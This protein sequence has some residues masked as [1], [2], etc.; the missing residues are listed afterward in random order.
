[1]P[2]PFE[3]FQQLS[4]QAA[5]I[6]GL[7]A[8][9]DWDQET[10]MPNDGLETRARQRS[11]LAQAHHRLSTGPQLAKA[12]GSCIDLTTG[13]LLVE[14]PDR[15]LR[16]LAIA[17]EDYLKQKKVPASWVKQLSAITPF[18][19]DAWARARK[20]RDFSL[21]APWLEKIVRLNQQRSKL[22]CQ[23]G[24]APEHPY[25]PL[26]DLFEPGL[27]LATLLTLYS[28]LQP[29]LVAMR[30]HALS[31]PAPTE[32]PA[33]ELTDQQEL[34][35][36]RQIIQQL[37]LSASRARLD[38]S[39]HPFCTSLAPG[40]ERLTTR[41]TAPRPW[42]AMMSTLHE[43]GHGLYDQG[44][45][46]QEWGLPGGSYC[47]LGMH[48]SQSR[49]WECRVGHS[50][51]FLEWLLQQA[52]EL[53]PVFAQLEPLQLYRWLNRVRRDPV[54]VEA[55]EVSYTLHIILRTRIEAELL[56]GSLSVPDLPAR[57]N[58]LSQE[59][60]GL[61]PAHDGEG[62]LQDVH[63]AHGEMGYFP[64]YALGNVYSAQLFEAF[65][66]RHP[67]WEADCRQGRFDSLRDWLSVHVWSAGRL[68]TPQQIIER[69]TSKTPSAEP[70]L[71]ALQRRLST[72]GY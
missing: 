6:Q 2:S 30:E 72:L 58:A 13:Q 5:D 71:R 37:G 51:A 38:I 14:G 29:A 21:F 56:D 67:G 63:W 40:D 3:R 23:G 49:L 64:S 18:A 10:M 44:L 17:R 47:S 28:Q 20:Q 8:L 52:R 53:S 66:E 41:L 48:E 45:D 54:R 46:A 22:L 61:H 25:D 4:Q 57:W 24:P 9:A 39:H 31:R 50:Y 36:C 43:A 1:M 65:E 32:P 7:L 55:D 11:W 26:L 62:C 33:C 34:G 35:W 69:A 60:L 68:Y 15:Q 59:L 16:N 70:Y 12:L 27:T 42:S 19:L